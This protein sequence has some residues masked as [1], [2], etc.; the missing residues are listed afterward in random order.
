MPAGYTTESYLRRLCS[1]AAQRRYG[2]VSPQVEQRLEEEFRLIRRHRLAGFL[3]LYREI[4]LIAQEV[5][6][7]QGMTRPETPLEERLPGRGRGS[8][9]ALARGLPRRHQ[10]RRPA[11]VGP[12]PGA[13][14]P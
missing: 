13:V 2:A 4:V 14:H 5:M 11:A 12:H 3:L 1:E 10:P 9:V 6:E 8:S 7:E